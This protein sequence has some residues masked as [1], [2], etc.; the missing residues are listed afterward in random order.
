[1]TPP[2]DEIVRATVDDLPRISELAGLIWRESYP[3]IISNEQ[4]EYMLTMMYDV[5]I[6]RREMEEEGVRY[7]IARL[8]GEWV[9]F[10]AYGPTSTPGEVKLHKL[11]LRKEWQ[12]IGL[13]SLMMMHVMKEAVAAG[14]ETITLNVNKGNA[15]AIRAYERSGFDI[16]RSVV[17]EIGG[18][19]VMDDYVMSRPL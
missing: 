7:D 11:Y 16:K 4:I 8:Y 5:D 1:M 13:G 6:M 15:K 12:G 19:Y 14:V 17:V 9:G 2:P 3:G 10:A 18:G